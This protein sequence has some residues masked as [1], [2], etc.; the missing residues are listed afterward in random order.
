MKILGIS[1]SPRKNE[2]SGVY[3][4]VKTVLEHTGLEY[5]M[6]SL[7]NKAISGCIACLLGFRSF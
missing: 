2:K 1:G 3:T 5:E 4:L 6:I 7:R